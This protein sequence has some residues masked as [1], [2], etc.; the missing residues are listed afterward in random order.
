MMLL[1]AGAGFESDD[2]R[3]LFRRWREQ[4]PAVLVVE[5]LNWMFKQVELSTF[6][7]LLDG[8]EQP[9]AGGLLLIGTTNHPYE[10]D[11]A[12]SDRPGR[13][14]VTLEVPCPEASLREMFF[15]SRANAELTG[16]L[17]RDLVAATEGLS[18]AHL[19]EVVQRAGVAAMRD[20]RTQRNADD[21]LAAAKA[22]AGGH[23]TAAAGFPR[24][25]EMPFGLHHL[26][27][28]KP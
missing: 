13:F 15:R 28:R 10:L 23:A 11:S 20:G 17:L 9:T 25:P 6:L 8:V 26:H 3:E 27:K 22:V 5:D 21:L 2:L 19:Q 24:K 7:N 14:D 12:I 18:F 16:D 4:A 1:R